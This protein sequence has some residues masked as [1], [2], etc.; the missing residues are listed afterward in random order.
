MAKKPKERKKTE[1]E[2]RIIEFIKEYLNKYSAKSNQVRNIDFKEETDDGFLRFIASIDYGTFEQRILYYPDMLLQE[3]LIDT[4]FSFDKSRYNYTF[5]DVFNLFEIDDFNLYFYTDP[6]SVEDVE[7]ALKDILSATEKYSYYLEKA[8]KEQ[9]LPQL[10]KNY[11]SDMGIETDEDREDAGE[12]FFMLPFNHPIYSVANGQITAKTLKKLQKRNAK[13]KLD[14]IYEK[15]LL[16]YLEGGK[17]F[18]R[19]AISD[20]EAFDKLYK[21]AFL[22][23]YGLIF[24]L[25]IVAVLVLTFF[26]HTLV[27]KGTVILEPQWEFIRFTPEAHLG[28]IGFCFCIG[29]MYAMVIIFSL[30]KRLVAQGMPEELRERTMEK[31]QS[32]WDKEHRLNKKLSKVLTVAACVVITLF[33]TF[34]FGENLADVGYYDNGVKFMSFSF[35]FCE[36]SYEELEICKIQGYYDSDNDNEFVFYENTFAIYYGDKNYIFYDVDP[37]G[38]TLKK[39]EEITQKYSKEIKEFK[40]V[41]EFYENT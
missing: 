2:I 19:K 25:S 5:Y 1:D 29:A 39:L 33:A 37:N 35:E 41:D 21:K 23:A 12:G 7:N 30:G 20:K 3:H 4:D 18:E 31:Y 36:V 24:L 16:K 11:E 27:F 28:R 32:D 38:E 8:Q 9:Y 17:D 15:R 14:T 6:I 22:K 34:M 10:E 26:V 13:G 40:T